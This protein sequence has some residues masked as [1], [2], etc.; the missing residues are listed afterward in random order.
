MRNQ[1]DTI[2]IGLHFKTHPNLHVTQFVVLS[3]DFTN[4]VGLFSE[5]KSANTGPLVHQ[6][7]FQV[8]TDAMCVGRV[9]VT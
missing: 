1:C 4:I 8:P 6:S 9:D 7:V 5:A 3:V 2:C